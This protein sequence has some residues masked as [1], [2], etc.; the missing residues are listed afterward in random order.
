MAYACIPFHVRDSELNDIKSS[1]RLGDDA[2]GTSSRAERV[3]SESGDTYSTGRS[4]GM[5]G[6]S[7]TYGAG[8]RQTGDDSDGFSGRT[9]DTGYGSGTAAGAGYGNKTGGY[10][11]QE[12]GDFQASEGLGDSTKTYTG[13]HDTYGSGATGGAGFGNKSSSHGGDSGEYRGSDGMGEHS[14]PYVGG[15]DTYGSGST[16]G[17]GYGN[18]SSSF[19]DDDSSSKKDSTAAR[20]T[21]TTSTLLTRLENILA[22]ALPPTST[23]PSS[24]NNNTDTT[25][26]GSSAPNPALGASSNPSITHAGIAV[27]SFNLDVETTALVK[28]AEDLMGL[29]RGL[30]EIW[31]GGAGSGSGSGSGSHGGGLD[32]AA[33]GVDGEVGGGGVGAR[34]EDVR[35]VLEGL[36][37]LLGEG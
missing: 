20:I 5:G 24:N 10:K 19:G 34:E 23:N 37:R 35:A 13:G 2:Y 18:K 16:G 30:K 21:H 32:G 27:E 22:I 11:E 4:G 33:E 28:A 8:G 1:A 29:G 36:G 26:P 3:A 6:D 17:A 12:L 9:Q 14:K 15:H 7:G 31:L 25:N